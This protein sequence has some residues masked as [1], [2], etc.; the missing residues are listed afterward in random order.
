MITAAPIIDQKKKV[1]VSATIL[2]IYLVLAA[3]F[4]APP[5]LQTFGM[6]MSD[7][8]SPAMLPLKII[9]SSVT[10]ISPWFMLFALIPHF[11]FG[12]EIETL[13]GSSR[14]AIALV[15]SGFITNGLTFIFWLVLDKSGVWLTPTDFIFASSFSVVL[16]CI[17]LFSLVVPIPVGVF[18]NVGPIMLLSTCG[19]VLVRCLMVGPVLFINF[20]VAWIVDI[21]VVKFVEEVPLSRFPG[22]FLLRTPEWAATAIA[23]GANRQTALA[24]LA[25]EGNEISGFR[26]SA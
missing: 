13:I 22:L 10:D 19:V 18:S 6:A 7:L 24:G 25:Q 12:F 20:V 8:Q 11:L 21:A 14:Y 23:D 2:G 4:V 1:F 17:L 3:H 15:A 16:L 26:S 5:L 9:S